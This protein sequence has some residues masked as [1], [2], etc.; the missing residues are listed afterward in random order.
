MGMNDMQQSELLPGSNAADNTESSAET[1]EPG[2]NETPQTPQ[3]QQERTFTQEDLDRIIKDRLAQE[4][5]VINKRY[6]DLSE[7]V[8]KAK[9]AEST[10]AV[11]KELQAK[12]AM[13]ERQ[14]A[15]IEVASEV[16]LPIA[17]YASIQGESKAEMR[18]SAKAIL[19]AIRESFQP[20]P[21]NLDARK[22]VT[23]T[24]SSSGG[25]SLTP[26][27]KATAKRFGISE[28]DYL[29]SKKKLGLS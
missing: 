5:A 11:V 16:G 19:K 2:N 29:E 25:I 3:N 6:G 12:M 14:T 10:E 26:E 21:P 17:V 22:G 24:S 4:R 27:E 9:K 23:Q 28:A 20:P 7:L 15:Q 18:E 13:Y 8:E 1:V